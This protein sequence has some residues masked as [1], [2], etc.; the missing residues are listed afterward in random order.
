[1]NLVWLGSLISNHQS[2]TKQYYQPININYK[3]RHNKIII[4]A[5]IRADTNL[6]ICFNL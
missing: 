6:K 3:M 2:M 5:L 4:Y 1:M